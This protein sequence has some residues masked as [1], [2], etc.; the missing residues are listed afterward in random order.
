MTFDVGRA[1]CKALGPGG[2]LA[3]VETE[4]EDLFLK[5]MLKGE[6]SA[7]TIPECPYVLLFHTVLICAYSK[8]SLRVTILPE[9]PYV[10]L[11]VVSG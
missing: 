7:T 10:C 3:S 11:I 5:E 6:T 4:D 1:R 8:V 9:C 2:D